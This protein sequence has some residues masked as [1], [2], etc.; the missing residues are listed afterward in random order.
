MPLRVG[1]IGLGTMGA[2]MA[3][4]L[5]KAG[6]PL[7]L[8][9]R[10]AAKARALAS[11]LPGARAFERFGDVGRESDVLVTCLPDAPE[12]ESVLFG[13]AGA[14]EGLASGA[15]VIDC[16]TIAAEAARAI[17]A[18]LS[19]RSVA[20]LDSP[21]SGGQKGAIEGAA[22]LLRRRGRRGARARAPGL[23][24]HG[25]ADHAPRPFRSGPA[26]QGGESDPRGRQPD[27]GLRGAR[28]RE[29]GRPAAARRSTRRSRPAPRTPGRS[30]CS[31]RR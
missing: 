15:I 24:G 5:A 8:A 28:F 17:A 27:R 23:P 11:E 19:E 31:G 13:P 22:D 30:K 10:T 2:P 25:K 21:V 20:L 1:L 16:S 4:N 29:T 18:R 9:T 3:R 6:F 14:A 12:V 7:S 26:R